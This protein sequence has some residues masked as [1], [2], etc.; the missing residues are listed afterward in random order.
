[1]ALAD[2]TVNFYPDSSSVTTDDDDSCEGSPAAPSAPPGKVCVY[3][4]RLTLARNTAVASAP[5]HLADRSFEIRLTNNAT[6][7]A[8]LNFT[9]AYTAPAEPL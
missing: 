4:Y 1:V 5:L 8:E 9:W 3:Q 2:T 7:T 6:G